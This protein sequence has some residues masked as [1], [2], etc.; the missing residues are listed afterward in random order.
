MVLRV[1]AVHSAKTGLPGGPPCFH[2]EHSPLHLTRLKLTFPFWSLPFPFTP[3]Y[4]THSLRLPRLLTGVRH[5]TDSLAA[6][7][8][9]SAT[10]LGSGSNGRGL[11]TLPIATIGMGTRCDGG[12]GALGVDLA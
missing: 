1:R 2:P 5:R 8:T 9:T 6:L 11:A 7:A 4:L 10:P 12:E 3:T